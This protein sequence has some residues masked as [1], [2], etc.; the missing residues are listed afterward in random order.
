LALARQFHATYERLAPSFGYE[1]RA[2]TRDFDAD[3]PNGRLMIAV[4]AE[5]L[6]QNAPAEARCKASPPAG[7]SEG[8]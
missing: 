2:E 6:E 7:C 5:I 8:C 1:T 4:C 3:F